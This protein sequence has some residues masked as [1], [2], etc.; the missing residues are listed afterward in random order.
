MRFISELIEQQS[1]WQEMPWLCEL[2]VFEWS[3]GQTFD[4]ADDNLFT[5]QDMATIAAE[6]WP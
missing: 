6:S 4:A 2:A 5:K 1:T 3:L